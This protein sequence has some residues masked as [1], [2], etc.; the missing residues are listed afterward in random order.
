MRANLRVLHEMFRK[1][2]EGCLIGK[3][4]RID[5][6]FAEIW[7]GRWDQMVEQARRELFPAAQE[8]R[9]QSFRLRLYFPRDVLATHHSR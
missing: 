3:G 8:R 9:Y 5:G 4:S 6:N 7:S 2:I 1:T